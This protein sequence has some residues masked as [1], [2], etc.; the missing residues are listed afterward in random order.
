MYVC[1]NIFICMY[2]HLYYYVLYENDWEN[3]VHGHARWQ[4]KT[5][6]ERQKIGKIYNF[7]YIQF[8]KTHVVEMQT[9]WFCPQVF[10]E[11]KW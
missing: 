5:I 8:R 10:P 3:K 1:M 9:C 4:K 6:N 7:N 2:A 11:R